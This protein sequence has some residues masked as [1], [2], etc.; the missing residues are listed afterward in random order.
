MGIA[1]SIWF[2]AD[3]SR[4][5]G[6]VRAYMRIVAPDEDRNISNLLFW[7][8]KSWAGTQEFDREQLI[9]W[10]NIISDKDRDQKQADIPQERIGIYYRFEMNTVIQEIGVR[11][12]DTG[13]VLSKL[14]ATNG[15]YNSR[16]IV[17]LALLRLEQIINLEYPD[18]Q[19]ES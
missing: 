3:M 16:L 5:V 11:I 12:A 4:Q 7:A 14:K 15:T 9:S 2:N 10:G 19:P 8:V 6:L 13:A 1:R 17:A 18:L